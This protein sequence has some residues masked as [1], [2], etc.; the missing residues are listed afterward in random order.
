[1]LS[2]GD[3]VAVLNDQ[4]EEKLE[5]LNTYAFTID[6]VQHV[7]GDYCFVGHKYKYMKKFTERRFPT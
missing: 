2:L 6:L 1:M 3:L 4:K 5:I 7:F